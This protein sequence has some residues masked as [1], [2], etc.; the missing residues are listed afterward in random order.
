MHT[1]EI[2]DRAVDLAG[3][4]GYTVRQEWFAGG[5]GCC[6]LR[7]QKLLFLDLDLPPDER[8]DQVL[9]ALQQE[10]SAIE[11]PMLQELRE[12]LRLRN[13]AGREETTDEH[14]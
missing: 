14:R 2:L 8:L 7:G 3:R 6:E 12:L 11:P 9:A 4:L 13:I 5:G 1:V 10:P